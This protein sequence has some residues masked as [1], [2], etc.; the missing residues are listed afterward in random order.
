VL[1][2]WAVV[3]R[4]RYLV[5]AVALLITGAAT[6]KALMARPLYR[7]SAQILI[8]RQVPQ[9]LEF[10]DV[11]GIDA[12]SWGDEYHLTQ[13]KLIESRSLA[14]RVVEKLGLAR[15]PE[16]AGEAGGGPAAV[17]QAVDSFLGR[18]DARRIEHSQIITVTFE[19]PRPELAAGAANTLAETFIEEAVRTRAET[20][21][22]V[23]SWLGAQIEEQRGKVQ[24][25]QDALQRLSEETGIVNFEERRALLDQKLKQLGTHLTEGKA[26]RLQSE[27]L[28]RAMS[29]VTDPQ[30]LSSVI[31][32]RTFQ[33]L[34]MDLSRLERKEAEL[35]GSG[36]LDKHPDVVK[37]RAEIAQTRGRLASA[38]AH[39]LK[40]SEN[41]YKTAAAQER[42]L[43][44]ALEEAKAEALDLHRRGLR[45]ESSKRDLEA[46]QAV[47]A[48]LLARSKQTEVAQELRAS[49]IRIVDRAAVPARPAGPRRKLTMA[50]GLLLG[51]GAGVALAL[52]VDRLDPRINTPHDVRARLGLPV[53]AV[54][55]EAAPESARPLL[56]G[57]DDSLSEAYR[58][59]R[60]ALDHVWPAGE[61]RT[62][63]LVSTAPGEGKTVCAVNLALALAARAEE[64]VLVDGD[65]R[66][67]QAHEML[68]VSR[69]PGLTDV[70]AGR[71]T[72][73]AAA[74][75]VAGTRLRVIA[76]G[77]A[78]ASPAEVLK[79]DALRALVADLRGRFRW[80]IFDS[81]PLGA[82]ADASALALLSDGVLL[83]V[84]AERTP[85]T[86]AAEILERLEQS[87]SRVLGVVL[88]RAHVERSPYGY[89]ARFGSDAVQTPEAKRRELA[90]AE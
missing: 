41:D 13:L 77:A 63:T 53:L 20:A 81:S 29:A 79:P 85:W 56:F 7:A 66:R 5:G 80:V 59:L 16:F 58:V 45:Y 11:V 32:N 68:A 74:Q 15:D 12:Q 65:L 46:G 21:G 52:L 43:G 69:T 48:S 9:V 72:A 18:V 87:G 33:D 70:L 76:S 10:R 34:G 82:V 50:L 28:H 83:V 40:A 30:D 39:I 84:A 31:S 78:A 24:A 27:A 89:G 62:L 44:R 35:L 75:E 71:V 38:A 4:W 25:A 2:Y 42:E 49:A 8:A 55:P 19:A 22:Q 36:K 60:A 88:N 26:R 64:V 67:P 57:A 90:A 17:E 86:A 6:L 3:Y 47:L 54:V 61:A 14:R 23:S 1:D 37:V 73:G 51:L